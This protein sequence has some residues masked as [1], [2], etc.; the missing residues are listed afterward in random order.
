MMLLTFKELLA[1]LEGRGTGIGKR[2][3]VYYQQLG[4]FPMPTTKKGGRGVHSFF[5]AEALEVAEYIHRLK[6]QGYTLAQIKDEMEGDIIK[7]YKRIDNKWLSLD[8]SNFIIGIRDYLENAKIQP[9]TDLMIEE[10]YEDARQKITDQLKWWDS[11]EKFER[12]VLRRLANELRVAL[13]A[14]AILS[15]VENEIEYE[16]NKLDILIK[17]FD[18]LK[19]ILKPL[20][21]RLK[22]LKRMEDMGQKDLF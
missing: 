7:R 17:M 9:F 20:V 13:T 11:E 5:G 15:I 2:T 1:A 10:L 3:I 18:K 22:D 4:I 12:V 19:P 6:L 21:E 8:R 16:S 14:P